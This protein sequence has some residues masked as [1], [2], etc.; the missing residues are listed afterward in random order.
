[1]LLQAECIAPQEVRLSPD[2]CDL[3][4]I[5]LSRERVGTAPGLR[6]LAGRLG[7]DQ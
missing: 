2:V 1:M 3:T 6:E 4:R 7:L 5:L